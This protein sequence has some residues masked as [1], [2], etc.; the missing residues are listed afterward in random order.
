[1]ESFEHRPVLLQA[2]LEKLEIEPDGV[3]VD[4]TFGRGGHS[5]A[6]LERLG[7]KGRLIVIDQDDQ[8]IAAA[9]QL[10][11]SDKRVIVA[12]CAFSQLERI[13]AEHG[14]MGKVNGVLLDLGVSS[15]QLDD[16]E[17]GFSFLREG[18]LDMRMDRRQKLTAEEWIN[19]AKESDIAQVLKEYGEE[20]YARRIANFI[21]RHRLEERITTTKQLAEIITKGN[22]KWE[23]RINPATR[24]FQ[25][26]RIFINREL[27]V[28]KEVLI[29]GLEVL[30]VG[31]RLAVI[32]FHSLEDRI[33][34][35]FIQRQEK[36]DDIPIEIPVIHSQLNIRM[37][38]VGKAIRAD[39]DE[40]KSNP[41][42]RSA[43]LRVAEKLQ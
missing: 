10:A 30:A 27:D 5:R 3:Y 39:E 12:H 28:L 2:V 42:S 6:I 17:R 23:R 16:P 35:R 36:G 32:S 25:G 38:R 19:S 24:S 20:R 22:P 7:E 15:P 33:V 21:C 26:I 18:P 4:A 31:G 41:R 1:M 13:V 14:F 34:K 9:E 29:Q 8:A 40:V 37:R 43:V 11:S